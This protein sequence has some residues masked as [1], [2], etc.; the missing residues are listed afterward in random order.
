VHSAATALITVLA[1]EKS[2]VPFYIVGGALAVW[3][4]VLSVL[5]G[6]RKPTFPY[7]L[8]GERAVIA[9]T[10]ALVLAAVSTAVLTSGSPKTSAAAQ[11]ASTTAAGPGYIPEGPVPSAAGS[12]PGAAAPESSASTP[13]AAPPRTAA[14]PSA[15]A[16]AT[17]SAPA[18]AA[19]AASTVPLAAVPN[20]IA[21]NTKT[22]SA[23]AGK[24]TIAFTNSGA[25]EHN[26]TIAQGNTVLGATPTFSGGAKSVT[27]TLKPGTYT[28]YCSVPGHRAAGMEGTLNVT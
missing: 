21:F 8:P 1:A 24:V 27:L 19:Q 9:I 23:K 14:T 6:L 15:P 18:P 25:L 10:V 11:T 20:A 4:V 2:K 17:P 5:I 13:A 28:F 3:A 26:V 7:S 12:A 16:P 22:L